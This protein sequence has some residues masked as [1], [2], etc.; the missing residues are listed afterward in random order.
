M[1]RTSQLYVEPVKIESVR[2]LG[3]ISPSVYVISSSKFHGNSG[4]MWCVGIVWAL[5]ALLDV[6]CGAC[7]TINIASV[8]K[9]HEGSRKLPMT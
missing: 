2:R 1:C 6:F 8:S 5:L 9:H 3:G 4:R 7:Y